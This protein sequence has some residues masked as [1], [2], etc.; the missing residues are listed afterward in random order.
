MKSSAFKTLGLSMSE[1][2]RE[3]GD[4]F[5]SD[6]EKSLWHNMSITLNKQDRSGCR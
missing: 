1:M 2:E 6:K 3:D 4:M 5:L